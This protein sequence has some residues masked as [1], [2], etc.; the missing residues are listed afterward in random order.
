MKKE[1][2][3]IDIIENVKE[4]AYFIFLDNDTYFRLDIKEYITPTEAIE[5]FE[6]EKL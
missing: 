1:I 2:K 3:I 5:I 6:K 4:S